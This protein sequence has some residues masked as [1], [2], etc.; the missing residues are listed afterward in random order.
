MGYARCSGFLSIIIMSFSFLPHNHN[1]VPENEDKK[2]HSLGGSR[3][4]I[5]NYLIFITSRARGQFCVR[6][7]IITMEIFAKENIYRGRGTR[8]KRTKRQKMNCKRTDT[9]YARASISARTATDQSNA[10]I[11]CAT[12]MHTLI[13]VEWSC[14]VANTPWK[15]SRLDMEQTHTAHVNVLE[16]E[17]IIHF[18]RF[19]IIMVAN[20]QDTARIH[21]HCGRWI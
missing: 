11:T 13:S 15:N 5:K 7:S 9:C 10:N 1:F 19:C 18:H 17:F 12:A 16:F 6:L 20:T 2:L 4:R 21:V 3:V 14:A 8:A